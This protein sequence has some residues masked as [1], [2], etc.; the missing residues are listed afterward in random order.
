MQKKSTE[1]FANIPHE[2]TLKEYIAYLFYDEEF[3]PNNKR[4][5]LVGGG[6]SPIFTDLFELGY[7]PRSVTNVDPYALPQNDFSQVLHKEDFLKYRI[8]ND[9]FDE[10]WALYSLPF[11]LDDIKQ[12]DLFLANALL[13]LAPNGNFRIYP[14]PS[15]RDNCLE[16]M[17]KFAEDFTNTFPTV[18]Y[19]FSDYLG[20]NKLVFSLPQSKEGMNEWLKKNYMSKQSF[21][22]TILDAL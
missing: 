12:T 20:T 4:I 18:K 19:E 8:P 21:F 16:I 2:R 11:W 3:N 10:I 5:L 6:N 17:K 9:F 22:E 14:I 7:W 1:F 13:G 15:N